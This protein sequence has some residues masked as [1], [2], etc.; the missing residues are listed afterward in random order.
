[1]PSAA[2]I[3]GTW[4]EDNGE[5]T[6]GNQGPRRSFVHFWNPDGS[7]D[8]GLD[9]TAYGL[10]AYQ[11]SLEVAQEHF[12]Q[13]VTHYVS[14]D[15]TG[16]Y[17]WLGRTAH[18]LQDLAVPAHVQLDPHTSLLLNADNYESFNGSWEFHYKH[19][20][21]L[22]PFTTIPSQPYSQ[23]LRNVPSSYNVTLTNLLF[24]LADKTD[25]FDS[26]D[27]DGDSD[28]YGH[29]KYRRASNMIDAIKTFNR[30]CIIDRFYHEDR[31]LS[32]PADYVI[33][34]CSWSRDAS[35]VYTLPFYNEIINDRSKG[36]RVYY[37]DNTYQNFFLFDENNVPWAVCGEIFQPQ[38]QGR[39]IGYTAALY[40][41]FWQVT[42]PLAEDNYEQNDDI[43]H[44]YDLTTSWGT[45]LHNIN[46][47]GKHVDEDW[48]KISVPPSTGCLYLE[49]RFVNSEGNIDIELYSSAGGKLTD[50]HSPDRDVERI[51]L[52]PPPYPGVYYIK[53]IGSLPYTGNT[54]DLW[55]GSNCTEKIELLVPPDR[56]SFPSCNPEIFLRWNL[57]SDRD[58]VNRYEVQVDDDPNFG[59]PY[60]MSWNE[61][62]RDYAEACY[63][64]GGLGIG[65]FYWRVRART[66]SPCNLYSEWSDARS[67]TIG[68]QSLSI[69]PTSLKSTFDPVVVRRVT[70]DWADV[71]KTRGYNIQIDTA[72][73]SFSHLWCNEL[74]NE[75]QATKEIPPVKHLY[76]RVMPL[77]LG[78]CPNGLWGSTV[79]DVE[80]R[81]SSLLP[82]KYSL[83]QS[84][85]NPFNPTT[86]ITFSLPQRSY[87]SLKVFDMIGRE[88]GVL[89]KKEL[90]AGNYSRQWDALDMPSGIYFYRLQAGEFVETKKM[91]LLK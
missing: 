49:C 37:G 38:L 27:R 54:Y 60:E 40:Q 65:T 17:Y 91:I 62:Q 31:T 18:L 73:A 57:V 8:S 77:G 7:Y 9:L 79:T 63:E 35:I 67:F 53:V 4:E 24:D 14:G 30:A 21:S 58:K 89:V 11:S 69:D 28:A 36:V 19:V 20:T 5:Y 71:P 32:T 23:Y 87:V 52:S 74:V 50:S 51:C 90:A 72:D 68:C 56:Y 3:E 42:H 84:Y 25:E 80:E 15:K 39:A 29:G 66:T 33:I 78:D 13:A 43:A 12:Y 85:P 10:G 70:F 88:V 6:V 44:A 59:S 34:A 46:G 55:W 48:F 2:L 75:S 83:C 82:T 16:A 45:W 86:M 41:L 76:W 22:S 47:L 1:V 64:C 61:P 81:E 26:D